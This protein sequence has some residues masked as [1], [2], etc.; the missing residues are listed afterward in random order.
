MTGALEGNSTL[1]PREGS[2]SPGTNP[3]SLVWKSSRDKD[4][5]AFWWER[6]WGADR[7]DREGRTGRVVWVSSSCLPWL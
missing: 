6:T 2:S 4:S 1:A 5:D 3:V 7:R